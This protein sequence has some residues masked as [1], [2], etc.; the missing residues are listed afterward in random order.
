MKVHIQL[1]QS[2]S[3]NRVFVNGKEIQP[4][5]SR[6]LRDHSPDG[7]AWGYHGSG[8]A[9][10]ALG[11]CLELFGSHLALCV[12]QDF[13]NQFV[14]GWGP[15]K[16]SVDI[17]QFFEDSVI[18]KVN[19]ALIQWATQIAWTFQEHS[20]GS[21]DTFGEVNADLFTAR[22]GISEEHLE[23]AA[24]VCKGEPG[25]FLKKDAEGWHILAQYPITRTMTDFL[26]ERAL[27]RTSDAL[28]DF[29]GALRTATNVAQSLALSAED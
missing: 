10:C 29:G 22:F 14:A 15:G 4:E 23:W 21:V 3:V 8:P 16:F 9:Q 24:V 19:T 11:I 13:K 28:S 27:N 18:P 6:L 26:I 20:L 25:Y 7:F 17:A 2:E 1:Q 12:Y 5:S